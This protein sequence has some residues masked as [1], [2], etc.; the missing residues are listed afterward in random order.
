MNAAS[1]TAI[2]GLKKR[3]VLLTV[4]RHISVVHRYVGIAIGFMFALWFATGSVLSFVPFPVLDSEDRIAGSEEIDPGK[5]RVAPAAA[6]ASVG[7]APVERLRLISVGGQPRYVAAI[8]GRG[9]ISVSAQT[10][11]LL[12]ALSS[13]QAGNVAGYFTRRPVVTVDGPFDYD[14]WTVHD[15]YDAYR[16]YYRVSVE[17]SLHTSVYVSARTGEILQ[18]TTRKQRAWNRVGA[19]IH[20]LNPT[21]LRKHDRLWGWTM[22]SVALAGTSLILMGLFLGT[23]RYVNLKRARRPGISPFNGWL[24]WHHTIGL[25]VGVIVLNWIASGWMSVERASFF[26]SDQPTQQQLERLRGISLIEAAHAFPTLDSAAVGRAR[27]IEFTALADQP[28]LIVR[29]DA[30]NT[31]VVSVDAAGTL[32]Q[33]PVI[34]DELLSTAVQSAWSPSHVSGIQEIAADDAYRLRT[35]PWPQ[36]ARRITLDDAGKTWVQIDAASGQIISVMDTSRRVYRWIVAGPHN[37]D[38]PVFNKTE[39]LRHI[40]IL[41][42]TSIGFTFSCTGVV[43]GVKRLRKS[44]R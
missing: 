33:S 4:S 44:L 2:S 18:R 9:L 41:C 25:F 7:A 36:T 40:L 3:P 42:A 11:E 21:I 37:L 15:R 43:L 13:A 35:V 14:Q 29:D 24:R 27:E 34:A 12:H 17:D 20:W 30:R 19:V 8:A 32:G 5:V 1:A 28:L 39:L 10:G 23:V 38:F 31:R 16:P 6:M 22:W 26:S